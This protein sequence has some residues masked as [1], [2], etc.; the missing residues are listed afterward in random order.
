MMRASFI[1]VETEIAG[2]IASSRW[3]N[4]E[5]KRGVQR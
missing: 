3:I 4:K 5:M 1:A 2:K